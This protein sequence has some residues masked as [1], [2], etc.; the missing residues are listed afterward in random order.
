MDWMPNAVRDGII[1][2]LIISGPIVIVAALIGLIVGVLQ[3][4]TQVQEQTIGSALK[5][6]GVFLLIILVGFWMYQYLNNYTSR[7]IST[8]FSIVP[9]QS[10][11]V[12]PPDKEEGFI[13]EEK[14]KTPAEL[15]VLPP[16]EIESQTEQG[17]IPQGVP[18]LGAP[19]IPKRPPITQ[20]LPPMII[21]PQEQIA[22][23]A[24]P[25]LN[26]QE[27]MT[28]PSPPPGNNKTPLINLVPGKPTNITNENE[29]KLMQRKEAQET[30]KIPSW[31]N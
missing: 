9:R 7:T 10:Q 31:I 28:F 6:I 19:Q 27:L 26:T 16:K 13:K 29:I 2:V 3:A 24:V 14:V 1:V 4:A 22:K 30:N 11:K 8:A 18:A 23:P 5:I 17:V 15:K 20:L 25:N 12:L 21:Q